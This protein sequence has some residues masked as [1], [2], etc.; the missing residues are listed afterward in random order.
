MKNSLHYI[1]ISCLAALMAMTS[2]LAT[3]QGTSA[4]QEGLHYFII[5]GAP[6]NPPE[7]MELI[8]AFSYLCTHCNTFEP[9]IKSWI[10]SR[11]PEHVGF[12]R[13]PV[14]FGRNSWELYARGYVTAEMLG[15]S[16]EAHE[17]LMDQLWKKKEILRNLDQLADFYTQFGVDKDKFIATSRSFA[18][19]GRLRKDQLSLQE[20]GIRGTPALVL[21]SKYRIQ[22]GAAV[23]NYETMLDIVD[24][25]IARES[26][27]VA[28][29]TPPVSE[30]AD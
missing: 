8:E 25:L 21:N 9:Y 20:Y 26:E 23:P 13:I 18:V 10:Q 16:E 14:V 2:Q 30:A 12:R 4:Y 3:A 24:Y 5:D 28:A 7:G 29:I 15:I 11:K 17:P 1:F 6:E 27:R 19:D 22:A